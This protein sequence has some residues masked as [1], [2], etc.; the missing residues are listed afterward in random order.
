MRTKVFVKGF[1]G[2][3]ENLVENW[4]QEIYDNYPD[5]HIQVQSN[6]STVTRGCDVDRYVWYT[7]IVS[8]N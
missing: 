4:L 7:V 8:T 6:F 1:P 2:D 3:W 5:S